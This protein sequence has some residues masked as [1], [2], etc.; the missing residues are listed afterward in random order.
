MPIVTVFLFSVSWV[1]CPV[2]ALPQ[3]EAGIAASQQLTRPPIDLVGYTHSSSGISKVVS[4][5]LDAEA[6]RMAENRTQLGLKRD[7]SFVGGS[8]TIEQLR[9]FFGKVVA[10]DYHEYRITWCGRFSI[11]FG[12]AA[13]SL[14]VETQ[15]GTQPEG[16]LLRYGTTLD[17]GRSD[18]GVE[19]LGVTAPASLHHWVGFAALGYR[20]PAHKLKKSIEQ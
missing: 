3:D 7:T 9:S 6:K 15:H 10:D 11:P 19:G 8:V 13:L 12:L 5:V 16:Y 2:I 20:I 4:H 1:A 17:P 18:P 14:L